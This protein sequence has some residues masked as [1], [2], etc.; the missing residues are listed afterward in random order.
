V[1]RRPFDGKKD[2]KEELDHACEGLGLR[3]GGNGNDSG[4]NSVAFEQRLHAARWRAYCRR[5]YA[6][7]VPAMSMAPPTL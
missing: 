6:T 4:F 1:S 7:A 5:F 3:H 2:R